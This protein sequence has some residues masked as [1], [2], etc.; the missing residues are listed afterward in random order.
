MTEPLATTAAGRVR[1]F[2]DEGTFVFLGL[3]FAAPPVGE[4]RFREPHPPAAWDG[5]RDA[6]RYGPT[7]PQRDPGATIIPEPVEA[8]DDYLNLNVFTPDLGSARLPVFVW[9][10]GGGFVS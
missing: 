1:G 2:V 6:L 3:P 7:A 4:L 10:H 9:I 5:V 8:G